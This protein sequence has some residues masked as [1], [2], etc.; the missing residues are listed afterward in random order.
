MSKQRNL[1]KANLQG[2]KI[3]ITGG[4][5]FIGSNLAHQCVGLGAEVTIFD[6]LDPRSGGIFTTCT[7]SK[8]LSK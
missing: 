2:Q 6:C 1:G 5:G 4:L 8:M 7:I 3:I